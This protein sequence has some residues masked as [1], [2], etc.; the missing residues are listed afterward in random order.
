MKV[1]PEQQ[2]QQE[3]LHVLDVQEERRRVEWCLTKMATECPDIRSIPGTPNGMMLARFLVWAIRLES[4]LALRL[5]AQYLEAAGGPP[6]AET[7]MPVLRAQFGRVSCP[8]CIIIPAS[9]PKK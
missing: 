2:Q 4:V 1:M 3:G 9:S 5:A 7:W 6:L 8:D